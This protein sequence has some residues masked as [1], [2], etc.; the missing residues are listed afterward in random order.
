MTTDMVSVS[1]GDIET[2]TSVGSACKVPLVLTS[3]DYPGTISVSQSP[4]YASETYSHFC[5]G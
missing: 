2:S 4:E 1:A 5:E 3:A